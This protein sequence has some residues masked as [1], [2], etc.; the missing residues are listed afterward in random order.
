[1]QLH[2]IMVEGSWKRKSD[3][4]SQYSLRRG[5][6]HYSWCLLVT[7]PFVEDALCFQVFDFSLEFQVCSWLPANCQLGE[8]REAED[9]FSAVT[10][11]DTRPWTR[12]W[13]REYFPPVR[14]F[15]KEIRFA[16]GRLLEV[17]TIFSMCPSKIE[18]IP[19]LHSWLWICLCS[20]WRVIVLDR[21]CDPKRS[22]K[23]RGVAMTRFANLVNKDQDG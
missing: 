23:E 2:T 9:F 6:C 11:E 22:E 14:R 10:R 15:S 3:C 5:S 18:E 8:E 7:S 1:M 4:N 17:S 12:P 21:A 13:V 20:S 16:F 19:S